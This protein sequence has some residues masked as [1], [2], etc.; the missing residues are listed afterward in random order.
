MSD[1]EPQG[2]RNLRMG[3]FF[4]VSTVVLFAA[5]FIVGTNAR[6]F[7]RKYELSLFLPN[8]QQL[9]AGSMVALSGLEI[10]K[11]KDIRLTRREDG[12]NIQVVL[13][14]PRSRQD[15]ITSSSMASIRTMGV[16]G[17]RFIDISMGQPGETPLPDDGEITVLEPTDWP[18]TFNKAAGALDDFLILVRNASEIIQ[19]MNEGPGTFAMLINDPQT[20]DDFRLTASDLA[21]VSSR[22]KQ[23]EGSHGRGWPGGKDS[24]GPRSG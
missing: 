12:R 8:A 9:G 7:E 14:L 20:A 11:V 22:L 3:V 6:L 17:D 15:Q 2:W 1:R 24:L 10:G 13:A 5:L 21:Q 18:A 19:K 16:L 23:G 4:L